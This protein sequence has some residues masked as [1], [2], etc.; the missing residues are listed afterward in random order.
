M[1]PL[2]DEL[3]APPNV[4]R[5]GAKGRERTPR[6]LA[7]QSLCKP[8]RKC[9]L[10]LPLLQ[11]L[12]TPVSNVFGAPVEESHPLIEATWELLHRQKKS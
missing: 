10:T 3:I 11:C 1:L 5:L 6:P 4:W 7:S 12:P 9:D 8:R 2:S